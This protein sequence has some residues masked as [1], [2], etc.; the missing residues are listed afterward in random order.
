MDFDGLSVLIAAVKETGDVFSDTEGIYMNS[1]LKRNQIVS[2]LYSTKI[3]VDYKSASEVYNGIKNAQINKDYYADFAIVRAGDMGSY[4]ASGYLQ[5]IKT[6]TYI[7]LDEKYFN[8]QAMDQLTVNG[9]VYGVVGDLTEDVGHYSCT[10]LNKSFASELDV[11]F[12]YSD[13]Y[14]YAFT[15]DKLTSMLDKVEGKYAELVSSY[16]NDVISYYLFGT[17]G[18]TYLTRN[19]DGKLVSTFVNDSNANLVKRIKEIIT[20]RKDKLTFNNTVRDENG[21][22]KTENVT[23]N[24]FDIFAGGRSLF[25]FGNLSDISKLANCGFDFEILPMPKSSEEGK[26]HTAVSFDAPVMVLL[27]SSPNIDTNGYILQALAAA[28]Q[29][30]IKHTFMKAAMRDYFTGIYSPD[31]LDLITENPI[32]DHAYM[33]GSKYSA[34]K[35][36]TYGAF[37]NAV[38]NKS[39][40]SYYANKYKSALE[41]YLKS[42][43]A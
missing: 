9:V 22:E 43:K 32:Y 16:G 21:N 11:G 40:L 18:S 10:F 35:N 33:F 29:G 13:V 12:D 37:Y 38:K 17:D 8:S 5:N 3:I 24:G 41:E 1:V 6:L 26:Y 2:D 25:A 7:D 34:I 39:T 4:Y 27:K 31:M 30:Y 42:T 14:G 28:S 36:G 20:H 19:A 15:F 23:L